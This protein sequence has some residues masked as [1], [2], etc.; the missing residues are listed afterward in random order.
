MK[1][2]KHWIRYGIPK[3]QK[4][5]VE[6]RDYLDGIVINAN[7][8]VHMGNA[9]AGF[10]A[11]RTTGKPFFIDP[12]THAFQHKLDVDP[13]T[14]KSTIK[15]SLKKL[16]DLYGE[17]IETVL[18]DDNP[19]SVTPDDF[20][21]DKAKAFCKRVMEFQKR[22]LNE[23]LK[24]R[25]SYEYLKFPK[26]E[27]SVILEP[28]FLVAPYFY[29]SS[30]TFDDWLLLNLKFIELAKESAK[31]NF[32]ND[33]IFA[34]I[35]IGKEVLNDAERRTDLVRKYTAVNPDGYLIWIDDFDTTQIGKKLLGNFVNLI[36]GLRTQG[37][38]VIN[39][40]GGYFS[41]LLTKLK[42]GLTGVVHG[43]E[44]GES[45]SV[46]PVGGGMPLAKY[47]FFPL[48]KRM[49]HGEVANILVNKNIIKKNDVKWFYDKVCSCKICKETLKKD[50]NNFKSFGL[51]K[52]VR[53]RPTIVRYYPLEETKD[54]CLRHYLEVKAKEFE[55]T[56]QN[57]LR[58]TLKK[59]GDAFKEYEGLLGLED[60]VYLRLWKDLLK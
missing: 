7:M 33:S 40:Y 42:D 50:M 19:R 32:P 56:K 36:K 38:P 13:E 8:V 3:D 46:V 44:Y 15:P 41:V 39:L 14:E 17:P 20:S 11:E 57:L 18:N 60:T 43:P 48:H 58:D 6:Y 12:L 54:R 26:E 31:K 9:I 52:L 21:G 55:E 22:H 34:E 51:S 28:I 4:Y 1:N 49:S 27:K 23:M 2:L 29:M 10:L 5:I 59:I 35:V 30:L 16:R 24:S 47:Y 53:L 37:N 25:E 45:R